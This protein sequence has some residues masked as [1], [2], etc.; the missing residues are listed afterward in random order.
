MILYIIL[1]M[2]YLVLS[3]LAFFFFCPHKNQFTQIILS[4]FTYCCLL[5]SLP[6][7]KRN[8]PHITRVIFFIPYVSLCTTHKITVHVYH[9]HSVLLFFKTCPTFQS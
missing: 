1:S 2:I 7:H 3:T 4:D 5:C 9:F 6:P 8:S